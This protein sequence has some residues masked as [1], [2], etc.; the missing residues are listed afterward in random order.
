MDLRQRF[1]TLVAIHRRRRGWTQQELA[2]RTD[3]SADMISRIET[4]GTGARFNTI[5]KLAAALETD[6]AGFFILDPVPGRD[7]RRQL[8]EL[9]ARLGSLPD[10]ELAWVDDLLTSALKGRR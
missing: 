9:T 2:D 6:P 8:V 7:M 1:G 10:S 5:E 3:M 4:G